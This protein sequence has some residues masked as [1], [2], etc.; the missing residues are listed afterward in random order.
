VDGTFSDGWLDRLPE[1]LT[2]AKP[3]LGKFKTFE[4]LAKSYSALQTVIGK[5][6]N[7]VTVPNEKST[8]EE[9]AAFRKAIGAPDSAE[10]YKLKP[11]QLPEGLTWDDELAK[12]FAEIAHKHHIPP[13]AMQELTARFVASESAKLEQYAKAATAE[14]ETGR[15]ELKKEFGANFDKSIVMAKRVAQTVGLDP[16][17]PG[18]RDPNV[19][20][21]LVR[22]GGMISEDKLSAGNSAVPGTMTAKDIMTNPANPYHKRYQE[23]DTEV[24]GM[25]RDLMRQAG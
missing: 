14:L 21:A 2:E 6:A 7:A 9:I 15:T 19:V 25:V 24:V 22:F 4:D 8:P 17:S 1:S 12:G 10:G 13:A 20:K 18:L 16:N 23:G 11:E 3:T 5:K